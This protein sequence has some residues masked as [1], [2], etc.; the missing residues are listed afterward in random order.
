MAERKEH[1]VE[2]V[3][4]AAGNLLTR[5]E[6]ASHGHPTFIAQALAAHVIT[7][8]PATTMRRPSRW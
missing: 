2:I 1:L 7:T 8:S 3:A 5:H 6:R 4:K